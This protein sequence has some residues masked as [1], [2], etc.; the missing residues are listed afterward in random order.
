MK[1][2]KR[3]RTALPLAPESCPYEPVPGNIAKIKLW[4]RNHYA[5]LAFNCC[6]NQRLPL[7]TSS[8]PWR[9]FVDPEATPVVVNSPGN[10]LL[11][12]EKDVKEELHHDVSI[13]VLEKVPVNMP[14]TWCSRMVACV[15]KSGKA[16]RTVDFK[17]V[18][19]AAPRQTNAAEPPFMQAASIPP[20]T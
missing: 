13:G 7:V 15:K 20:R 16:R 12:L 8:P 19:R 2:F 10:T 4:I 3:D 17:A 6:T 18:N 14:S 1:L 11:H 5:S 9:L